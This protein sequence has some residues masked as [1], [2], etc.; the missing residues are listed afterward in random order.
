MPLVCVSEVE[1]DYPSNTP[2]GVS[3]RLLNL[4]MSIEKGC[5][6]EMYVILHN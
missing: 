2:E 1:L 5:Y 6:V 3:S 4:E